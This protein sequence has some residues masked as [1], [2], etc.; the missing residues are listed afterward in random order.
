MGKM[1]IGRIILG[2]IV[3]GIVFNIVEG[4]TNGVLLG[5]QWKDW[6]ARLAPVTQQP[7]NSTGMVFWTVLAFLLGIVAVWLYAAIRPRFGAGAKTA[8][9]AGFVVWIIYWPLVNLQHMALGIIPMNML[10]I[11]DVGG[12]VGALLGTI[13]GAAI[14]KET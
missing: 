14:Y 2:G 11:G 7:S 12:L 8:C 3:A 9:I 6:G 10:V 5:Q 4:V 1:N 13:A